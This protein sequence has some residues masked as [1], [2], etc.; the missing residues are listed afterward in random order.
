M[1]DAVRVMMAELSKQAYCPPATFADPSMSFSR[2]LRGAV[3]YFTDAAAD[4]QAYGCVL[5]LDDAGVQVQTP[6]LAYRGTSSIWDAVADCHVKLTQV[7]FAAPGVRAHCGFLHDMMALRPQTDA[8]LESIISLNGPA[9][10]QRLLCT[11]HSMAAAV[12]G[13]AALAYAYQGYEVSWISFGTPRFGNGAFAAD[14]TARLQYATWCSHSFDPVCSCIPPAFYSRVGDHLQLA[15]F[16]P[17]PDVCIPACISD[18]DM[19]AYLDCIRRADIVAG[20]SLR[21]ILDYVIQAPSSV[22]T[23]VV[24]LYY[25]WK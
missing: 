12:S 25:T 4:A 8:W 15:H 10:P 6:V 7:P 13:V 23:S 1:K 3:A 21:G 24:A 14:A 5:D 16:D 18:H 2:A 22:L 11:G 9:A 19:A 17:F 20:S